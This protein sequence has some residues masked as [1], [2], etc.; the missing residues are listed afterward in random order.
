M[1][2]DV[3]K[4]GLSVAI[5]LSGRLDTVSSPELL[6][7]VE[8]LTSGDEAINASIDFSDVDFVSSAGLRV[9]LVFLKKLNRANGSL[10]LNN[11]SK[12]I[13]EVF[14]MTGFS[15]ILKIE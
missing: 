1:N 14:D 12:S 2:I 8:Q 9:L 6:E 10:V 5:V 15:A 7:Q 13:K 11:L 3:K 4:D